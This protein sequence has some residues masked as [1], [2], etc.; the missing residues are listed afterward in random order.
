MISK[1]N[2]YEKPIVLIILIVSEST[3]LDL[4][5]LNIILLQDPIPFGSKDYTDSCITCNPS[6]GIFGT[7]LKKPAIF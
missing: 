1:R 6:L 5:A 3:P 4:V 7:T 2:N